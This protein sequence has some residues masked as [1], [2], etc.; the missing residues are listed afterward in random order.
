M[1]KTPRLRYLTEPATL[2]VSTSDS[3][4]FPNPRALHIARYFKDGEF[5]VTTATTVEEAKIVMSSSF[6]YVVARM[7]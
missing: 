3:S 4:L 6:E 2:R 5:E 7:G 1:L